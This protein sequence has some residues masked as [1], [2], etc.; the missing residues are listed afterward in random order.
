[1]NTNISNDVG[2]IRWVTHCVCHLYC[3]K[4]SLVSQ[5]MLM[6]NGVQLCHKRFNN[7]VVLFRLY[8]TLSLHRR[9]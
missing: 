2:T 3:D 1:M 7:G 4:T 8:D 9:K 5:P 6:Q